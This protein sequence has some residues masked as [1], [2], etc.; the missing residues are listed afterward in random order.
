LF[1]W[2]LVLVFVWYSYCDERL[3]ANGSCYRVIFAVSKI[4]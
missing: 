1:G 3:Y 4:E 2:L